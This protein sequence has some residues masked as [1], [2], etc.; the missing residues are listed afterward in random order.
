MK[1][2]FTKQQVWEQLK[3]VIDPELDINIVDLGLIYQIDISQK[4]LADRVAPQLHVVM[5]LTT[6]GCPL[7]HVIQEM[8]TQ[9][10]SILPEFDAEQDLFLEVV[11]DPP[12][13]PDMMS[14][15][16]RAALDL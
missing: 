14:P 9:A 11:F 7:G 5:T 8:I 6:P 13:I 4:Q 10:L 16:A 3:T 1:Q 15:E 2:P 12:W